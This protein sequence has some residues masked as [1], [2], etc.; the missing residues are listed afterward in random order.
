LGDASSNSS[1]GSEALTQQ[2]T[3][4]GAHRRARSLST[5]R[6][7]LVHARL[8]VRY[9][10]QQ[11]DVIISAVASTH[12]SGLGMDG[13]MGSGG[14]TVLLPGFVLVAHELK[15]EFQRDRGLQVVGNE[16]GAGAR[17]AIDW[18]AEIYRAAS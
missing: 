13:V 6:G 2:T 9:F 17:A 8:I 1:G 15:V 7:A 11:N 5:L 4:K 3:V 18:G 12:D 14:E 16:I 10:I